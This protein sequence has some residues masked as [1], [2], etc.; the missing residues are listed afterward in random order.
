[1]L[2]GPA[3]ALQ[4]SVKDML[5]QLFM[6]S[7]HP[8][9]NRFAIFEDDGTSAWLYLT[10]PGNLTLASDAW[11]YNRIEAP[12]ASKIKSY[13]GG[14]PP[15]AIGYAS[16]TALCK[17]P[18]AHDWQIIWAFDGQSVALTKDGIPVGCI[19]SD[20]KTSYSRELIKD[21]PW[22]KPWSVRVFES[23]F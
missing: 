17:L 14:P 23:Y 5:Q 7:H 11:I 15:A 2:T 13:R 9:S 20:L 18:Q 1:M 8:S 22:G 6:D 12:P 4:L 19:I 3:R 10:E 21:G 16:E